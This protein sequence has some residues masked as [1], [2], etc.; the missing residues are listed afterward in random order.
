MGIAGG[1][2]SVVGNAGAQGFKAQGTNIDEAIK[3]K[4][5]AA[6]EKRKENLLAIAHQY[7]TQEIGQQN[8][9]ATA[10]ENTLEQTRAINREKN[11][12]LQGNINAKLPTEKL[13]HEADWWAETLGIDKKEAAKQLWNQLNKT[14]SVS[15][16]TKITEEVRKFVNDGD[17]AGANRL[18]DD[19][20]KTGFEMGWR[21]AMVNGKVS[22]I[23]VNQYAKSQITSLGGN[24]GNGDNSTSPGSTLDDLLRRA[25][26]KGKSVSSENTP[27]GNNQKGLLQKSFYK[28]VLFRKNPSSV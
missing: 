27:S 8:T 12:R 24:V 4:K 23:P 5:K 22:S 2:L 21:L 20:S 9:L 10:R 28:D 17:I 19:A 15:K 18:L 16:V 13:D 14:G 26:E 11:T 3:A 7:R 25:R 1:L 6:L